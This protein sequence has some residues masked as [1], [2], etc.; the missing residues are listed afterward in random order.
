MEV[1]EKLVK[2]EERL[3]ELYVCL[4]VCHEGR[5]VGEGGGGQSHKDGS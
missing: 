2:E 1:A 5:N 3:A 4:Y